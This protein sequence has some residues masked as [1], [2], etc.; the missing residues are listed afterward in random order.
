M[1]E[2]RTTTTSNYG[3]TSE[4]LLG[5]FKYHFEIEE[6]RF[7][8]VRD[9]LFCQP[10]CVEI[11]TEVAWIRQLDRI[12]QGEEPDQFK[13]PLEGLCQVCRENK[14]KEEKEK[15]ENKMLPEWHPFL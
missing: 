7:T 2:I 1:E 8:A 15:K 12:K 14:E 13:I 9:Y 6:S 3:W 11:P 4:S 5:L 10:A